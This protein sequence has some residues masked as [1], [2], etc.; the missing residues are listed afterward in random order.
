MTQK[1]KQSVIVNLNLDKAKKKRKRRKAKRGGG[2]L[3][4]SQGGAP[5]FP[6]GFPPQQQSVQPTLN[7]ITDY[8]KMKEG[9]DNGRHVNL[10]AAMRAIQR[11]EGRQGT[12]VQTE[13]QDAGTSTLPS[14]EEE[15]RAMAS[16]DIDAPKTKKGKGGRKKGS[17]KT[18]EEKAQ[19]KRERDLLA[20][21]RAED[22]QRKAF[23]AGGFIA[24]TVP[25]TVIERD[26]KG[27]I[28]IKRPLKRQNDPTASREPSEPIGNPTAASELT[29]AKTFD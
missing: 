9:Q 19:A 28:I 5:M 1:Q 26:P 13:R 3:R 4:P 25:K 6:Y 21:L 2:G 22:E 27:V 24:E 14:R 12:A 8:L 18:P 20:A 29:A 15:E 23:S 11:D 16:E 7:N 17:T 10:M